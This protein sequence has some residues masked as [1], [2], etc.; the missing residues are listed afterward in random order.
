MRNS[1]S[2]QNIAA[3]SMYERE[4]RNRELRGDLHLLSLSVRYH[5]RKVKKKKNMQV[6]LIKRKQR[7]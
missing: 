2:L 7:I 4:Y 6:V 5:K 3:L 1:E